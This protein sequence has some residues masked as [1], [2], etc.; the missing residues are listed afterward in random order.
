MAQGINSD[1][2][3]NT[4][5]LSIE[6]EKALKVKNEAEKISISEGVSLAIQN[7][8]ILPSLLKSFNQLN[9][10]PDYNYELDE[11]TFSDLTKDLSKEYWEEF[12][13]AS[14]KA[15][16]YQIKERL[17]KHQEANQ[18]LSTLGLTGTALSLGAAI[19][20]PVALAADA[21]TF[22]VARPYID[23]NRATRSSKY[24]HAGYV[25]DGQPE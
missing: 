24:I 13:L 19:L 23:A 7:E 12:S 22:G 4:D 15:N 9:L 20:D 2:L 1:L 18:K 21:V 25:G 6:D 10:E 17:L 16:A 11:E 8:Q 14:S 5:Y 3:L